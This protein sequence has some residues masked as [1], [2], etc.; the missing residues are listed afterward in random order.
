MQ[1]RALALVAKRA[2]ILPMQKDSKTFED[3]AKLAS[4]A[5][6]G[7]MDIKRELEAAVASKVE[8]L[9]ARQGLVTR[10]EFEAVRGMAQK[11]REETI[12]LRAELEALKQ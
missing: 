3:F 5:A 8:A 9:L 2:Y 4:G 7:F 10:E 11:A 6:G 1:A 12:A